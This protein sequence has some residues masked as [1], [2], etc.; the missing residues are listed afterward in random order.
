[1]PRNKLYYSQS[2]HGVAV[3]GVSLIDFAGDECIA[4]E[5]V[6]PDKVTVTEGFDA[7]RIS[8]GAGSAGKITVKLKPTS[9]S[10]GYLNALAKAARTGYPTLV[11]VAITTGVNEMHALKNAV[12]ASQ[13]GGS[14]APQMSERTFVFTGE[15]L[16]E[17]ESR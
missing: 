12:V 13:G 11:N 4:W 6:N 3:N 1:M 7:S 8:V 16:S 9:P 2:K 10:V 5:Y 17:D 14:G 15:E